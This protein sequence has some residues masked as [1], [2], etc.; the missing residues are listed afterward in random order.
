[1]P[2]VARPTPMLYRLSMSLCSFSR[3][4][5][6]GPRA[7]SSSIRCQSTPPSSESLSRGAISRLISRN[8]MSEKVSVLLVTM[9]S[10]CM[11]RLL[12][13]SHTFIR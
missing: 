10:N 7:I 3:E 13:S 11:H 12:V 5:L 2:A 8:T 6:P 4:R 9:L 1:M